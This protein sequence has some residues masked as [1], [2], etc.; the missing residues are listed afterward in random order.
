MHYGEMIVSYDSGAV[1]KPLYLKVT[2][3]LYNG[4]P[5]YQL[6]PEDV[7]IHGGI[8]ISLPKPSNTRHQHLGLYFRSNHGWVFQTDVQDSNRAYYSTTLSRTLGE[9]AVFA[10]DQQPTIGSLRVTP[11]KNSVFVSFRYHDNLSGVDPAEIKL[12][13]DG[14]LAIPELDGE[15]SRASYASDEPLLSGKHKLAISVKDRAKNEFIT[16]RIFK[17]R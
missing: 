8:T 3:Q 15:H 1:Y 12:Y 14:K 2:Q 6:E 16:E 13:I 11:R 10:D 17:T 7:L 9:V 5:A 4:T